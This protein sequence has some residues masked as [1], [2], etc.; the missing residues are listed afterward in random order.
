MLSLW[1]INMDLR[2]K[3]ANRDLPEIVDVDV[4][5]SEG[6]VAKARLWLPPGADIS[7]QTKYPML[8]YV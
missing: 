7:G 8:V 5:L 1:E 4:N 6:F 3:I 2:R